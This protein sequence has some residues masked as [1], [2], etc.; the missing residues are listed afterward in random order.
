MEG[1]ISIEF[2]ASED[3]LVLIYQDNGKG[4]D[5]KIKD[6]IFDPFVTTKRGF[7]GSGLGMNIVYNLVNTKLGG[8]IKIADSEHGCC[9]VVKVPLQTEQGSHTEPLD[10]DL[11]LIN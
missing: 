2:Q 9:F 1:E 6:K 4:L 11:H 7:G 8:S 5:E 10:P 3:S